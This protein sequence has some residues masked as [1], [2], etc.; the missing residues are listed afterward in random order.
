V[1]KYSREGFRAIALAYRDFEDSEKVELKT[2][3][4]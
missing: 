1:Q 4:R 3:T 2:A